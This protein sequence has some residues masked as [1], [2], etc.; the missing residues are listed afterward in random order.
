MKSKSGIYTVK[1]RWAVLRSNS[2]IM[3]KQRPIAQ[4]LFG[5]P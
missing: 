3:T 2:K 1:E 5:L 4:I